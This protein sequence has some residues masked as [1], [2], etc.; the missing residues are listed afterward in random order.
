VDNLRQIAGITGSQLVSGQ[1]SPRGSGRDDV[2]HDTAVVGGDMRQPSTPGGIPQ[3]VE[4]TACD[5]DRLEM[6][7]HRDDPAVLQANGFQPEVIGIGAPSGGQDDLVYLDG[8]ALEGCGDG[9]ARHGPGYR[10][11]LCLK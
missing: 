11:Q 2:G 7:V 3:G 6:I 10:R 1:F 5:A 9:S 4:P 8:L